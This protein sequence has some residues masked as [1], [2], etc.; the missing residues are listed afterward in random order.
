MREN[1]AG[2]TLVGV[3]VAIIVVSVGLTAILSAQINASAMQRNATLRTGAIEIARSHM[4]TLKARD[5]RTVVAEDAVQVDAAGLASASGI[6]ERSV[7]VDAGGQGLRQ[8]TVRVTFPGARRPV[9][10]V[11][12]LYHREF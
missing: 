3:L 9:E 11:T 7:A 8:V 1:R 2:F 10:L 5:P 6:F 12:L 4:E